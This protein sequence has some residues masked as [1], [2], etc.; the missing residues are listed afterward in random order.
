MF[1]VKEQEISDKHTGA[2]IVLGSHDDDNRTCWLR[3]TT[4]G[5]ESRMTTIF[6]QR[7]GDVLSM[8]PHVPSMTPHMRTED[9]PVAEPVEDEPEESNAAYDLEPV[10]KPMG[11]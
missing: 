8:T 7:D 6:F 5:P 1:S 2:T 10:D 11:V 3:V 9:E 4:P